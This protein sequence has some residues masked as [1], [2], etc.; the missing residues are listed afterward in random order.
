MCIDWP[1]KLVSRKKHQNCEIHHAWTITP[2]PE[3]GME[4]VESIPHIDVFVHD[5]YQVWGTCDSLT[6]NV[7]PIK[8][9]VA[10]VARK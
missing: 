7:I 10:F 3:L 8:H 1:E 2:Q 5:T 6:Y 9:Q 4:G